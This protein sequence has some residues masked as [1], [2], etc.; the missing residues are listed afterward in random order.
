MPLVSNLQE[1]KDFKD[2][3]VWKF[4]QSEFEAWAEDIRNNLENPINTR[5]ED[6]GLKGNIMAVR[7]MLNFVDVLIEENETMREHPELDNEEE[8]IDDE[9]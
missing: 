3:G 6:C 8:D 9:S 2:S 7:N 5:E 1:W 4:M